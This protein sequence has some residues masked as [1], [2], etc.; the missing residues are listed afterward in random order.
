MPT[1]V[2]TWHP[3]QTFDPDEPGLGL[4]LLD[5]VEH[6][7]IYD[8]LPSACNLDDGGTGRYESLRHGTYS[9]HQ[10]IVLFEDTFIVYWTQHSRDEN[11]PGQ[12]LLA[13]V[14]TFNADCTDIAW[15]G[16]ETLFEIAPAPVPVRRKHWE[17]DP[18]LVY[19]T[20]ASGSLKLIN[21]SLYVI[22]GLSA[23]HG[24][25]DDVQYHGFPGKPLP[26]E[27]WFD[28]NDNSKGVHFDIWW[29]LGCHFVQEWRLADGRLV[30]ASPLY[31]RNEPITRVEVAVGRFK[32]DEFDRAA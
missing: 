29:D 14:G 7:L 21:G 3:P 24:W 2:I 13:K 6:A 26:P 30:A 23:C 12:R 9:H 4:P 25:T 31:K 20:Y 1:P 17:H 18:G 27:R 11:G 19:E 5:G 32:L 8:P 28:A 16:D 15:G 10:K 22:G